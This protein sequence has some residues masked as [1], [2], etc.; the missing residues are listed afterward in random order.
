[1]TEEELFHAALARSPAERAGFL[2]QACSGNATLR[3]AVEALVAAHEA[4]GSILNLNPS[5][6]NPSEGELA[7][8]LDSNVA[9][10][11]DHAATAEHVPLSSGARDVPPP[12]TVT[13][14]YRR[15]A[16]AGVIVGGRYTLQEKIGEGGMGEVWVA[17]QT[18]PVKRK[19][20]LKLIKTGIDCRTVLQRFEQERQALALMDHPNIARV[21]DGGMVGVDT[22]RGDLL[23][24]REATGPQGQPFFVMELVNGLPLNKFCDEMKLTLQAR[25]ELFVPICQAVQHAHQKGI[26]HRDL[27]PANILVTMI[28]G[29]PVPKVIDFGVAKATSGKLTE[30]T[31]STGFGA[32]VGT[33]EYMAPEQAG[34]SGEDIDTRADIYSLGVILYELLTG[35]RPIDAKR[36]RRAALT[37]MIRIIQEEEPSK[38]STRLST[39]ESL[40][41]LAAVRQTEPKKLM[42]LLRG[43]LDW[44]VMKCLEKQR[45]RRYET[46]N[47]LARDVQRFLADEVVEAQPP[48]AGYRLKKF[49]RRNRGQVV[50]AS[51]VLIA[52]LAG[53]SGTTIGLF[54][55]WK[56]EQLAIAA[57]NKE[58]NARLEAERQQ[59][60]AEKGEKLAGER[61]LQV[62]AEKKI[63]VA[64]REFL[65]KKL[66]AQADV[67]VQAFSQLKDGGPPSG[68]KTKINP[69]IREL[70]DRAAAELS[71]ARVEANFPNQPLLQAEILLT[72]GDTYR[73]IGEAQRAIGFLQRAVAIHKQQNGPQHRDTLHCMFA[74]AWT[75][76]EAGNLDTA[77][78]LME[79]TLML[80]KA[81]LGPDHPDTLLSRN[82]LAA[83]YFDAGQPDL[84]LPLAEE[85]YRLAKA[86]LG[87][88]DPYTLGCMHTLAEVYRA[89]GKLDL[90]LPLA[91]ETYRLRIGKF[92]AKNPYTLGTMHTLASLYLAGGNLNQALPLAEEALPLTRAT[93]G[94]EHPYTI[95]SMR[96]LAEAYLAAD[97]PDLA[98]PL[99]E[100]ALQL[101]RATLGSEHRSTLMS[102]QTVI[103]AYEKAGRRDLV[104]PLC[105]EKL[106]LAKARFG[107]QHHNT[108][109]AMNNLAKAYYDA[110]EVDLALPLFEETLRLT[111]AT[112]GPDHPDTLLSMNSLGAAYLNV[113]RRDLALP[114]LDEA[115]NVRKAKFGPEHPYTLESM[116]NLAAM[117]WQERRLN[118]SIPLFE[119]IVKIQEKKFGRNHPATQFAVA[120]LGVNYKDGG[121]LQDG[122]PLLEE[123]YQ[124]SKKLP[125]L[126][127]AGMALLDGYGK[128]GMCE[129]AVGLAKSQLTEA[130]N[131]WPKDSP[132][133]AGVLAQIAMTYLE[134]QAGDEAE[135]LLRESLTI[136][137]KV[138]PDAWSTFNT[139]A[140]LGGALLGQ[141]QYA[142]SEPLLVAGYEGMKQREATIPEQGKIR[143]TEA[144]DRLIELYTA[145]DKPDE[146]TKWQAIK[147]RSRNDR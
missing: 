107:P 59:V 146:V 52:L 36:L 20:A 94:S 77:L 82:D 70:L 45:D 23:P 53:F 67:S 128:A 33:L 134:L 145:T 65:Q 121:R 144:V 74:L 41:S 16:A 31:M 35:L 88:D 29:K 39:D 49:V 17:K 21:L 28:D 81:T 50:A 135:P 130:R 117:Y 57:A 8:T 9:A 75:H 111:K 63:A 84:A 22:S 114:L 62:E 37:E 80:R 124:S 79:E 109:A 108:L 125:N 87:P 61:L 102:L 142:E 56:Q 96:T 100:E 68:V 126:R 133:L 106:N 54:E 85:T 60:R 18:E 40:P 98:V 132:Q 137:E 131:A 91:E 58:R 101:T 112:L 89:A 118:Q 127:F 15:D 97:K 3:A 64:V 44:V 26:V 42:A 4:P 69:T 19:V 147:A 93:L 11:K 104:L 46:A 48:S 6:A 83:T 99:A 1:M 139:R 13:T 25:L 103:A 143:L 55:A 138:Q 78:S 123:A 115:L 38:P 66:L 122:I 95:A 113:G 72:L 76:K 141:K 119:E 110:G 7:A 105:Q 73:G 71:D 136:R 129:Q 32:V 86:T 90:A 92:G 12:Q 51:L 116:N 140:L 30:E 5:G 43:E 34:F 47:A 10:G 14:D 24:G 120:N 2:D 27:K